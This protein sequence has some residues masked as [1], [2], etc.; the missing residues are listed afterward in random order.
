MV[1]VYSMRTR[2]L[3]RKGSYVGRRRPHG[4][5]TGVAALVSPLKEWQMLVRRLILPRY[6]SDVS[7]FP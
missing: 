7:W 1:V 3:T 2:C 5:R 6:I 4:P